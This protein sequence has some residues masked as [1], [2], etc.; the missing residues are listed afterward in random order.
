MERLL[1]R[2]DDAWK[3][4]GNTTDHLAV[5]R[6]AELMHRATRRRVGYK[7]K[8]SQN[9]PA[10]QMCWDSGLFNLT[11][12]SHITGVSRVTLRKWV[13]DD[14]EQ[15]P[16]GKFNPEHLIVLIRQLEIIAQ[17]R[18]DTLSP[19][20]LENL[21]EE[22]TKHTMSCILLGINDD[23]EVVISHVS[24]DVLPRVR[25]HDPGH[26]GQG[27]GG[28]APVHTHPADDGHTDGE[29]EP[30][31]DQPGQLQGP[32]PRPAAPEPGPAEIAGVGAEYGRVDAEERGEDNH[33]PV[34][35]EK[36]DPATDFNPD[37]DGDSLLGRGKHTPERGL[38]AGVPV[39][40]R[41]K[42][43]SPES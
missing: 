22:G 14:E 25:P 4:T 42:Q 7:Q 27:E 35:G 40:D 13:G 30:E 37:K 10:I 28:I 29:D 31:P 16:R 20:F 6:T 12:L 38:L 3:H 26:P 36:W 18:F 43:A 33:A 5:L 41:W 24:D 23:R 34:A 9:M 1:V 21:H 15:R 39:A 19:R 11:H 17:G 8:R 2:E 32:A